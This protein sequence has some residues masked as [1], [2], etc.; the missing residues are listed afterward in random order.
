[1]NGNIPASISAESSQRRAEQNQKLNEYGSTKRN[2]W[3]GKTV[4]GGRH[5]NE[6]VNLQL[7]ILKNSLCENVHGVHKLWMRAI[8]SRFRLRNMNGKIGFNRVA[9]GGPSLAGYPLRA[10]T[11]FAFRRTVLGCRRLARA[12][13]SLAC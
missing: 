9:L 7:R 8:R 13:G 5:G 2:V 4:A 10:P 3:S 11:D 12:V 6:H 1:M